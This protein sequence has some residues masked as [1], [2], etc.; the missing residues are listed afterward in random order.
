MHHRVVNNVDEEEFK[1]HTST[2]NINIDND[3]ETYSNVLNSLIKNNNSINR[4]S[5]HINLNEATIEV[6]SKPL[7]PPSKTIPL[8]NFDPKLKIFATSKPA[9]DFFNTLK[10]DTYV[11]SISGDAAIGKSTFL[12]CFIS[13]AEYFGKFDTTPNEILSDVPYKPIFKIGE[14]TESTTQGIDLYHIVIEGN[15]NLLILD[16]EGDNDPNRQDF[17]NWFYVN[18]ITTAISVSHFHNYHFP[19]VPQNTFVKYIKSS[20]QLIQNSKSPLREKVQQPSFYFVKRDYNYKTENQKKIDEQKTME[21]IKNVL[22]DNILK[23]DG[24]FLLKMPTNHIL[25]VDQHESCI[26]NKEVI[27][28]DCQKDRY[29]KTLVNFFFSIKF[30]MDVLQG[31]QDGTQFLDELNSILIANAKYFPCTQDSGTIAKFRMLKLTNERDRILQVLNSVKS[32]IVKQNLASEV[33]QMIQDYP[34]LFPK[35]DNE[36]EMLFS[37]QNNLNNIILCVTRIDLILGEFKKYLKTE[38]MDKTYSIL[39]FEELSVITQTYTNPLRTNFAELKMNLQDYQKSVAIIFEKAEEVFAVIKDALKL[40]KE[41]KK[42]GK[43]T[44]LLAIPGAAASIVISVAARQAAVR[45][46]GGVVAVTSVIGIAAGIYSIYSAKKDVD[47]KMAQLKREQQK[48]ENTVNVENGD[49]SL[50]ANVD[51]LNDALTFFDDFGKNVEDK[52]SKVAAVSNNE[53]TLEDMVLTFETFL[54]KK[55][56]DNVQVSN[57]S[58]HISKISQLLQDSEQY[59]SRIREML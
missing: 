9:Q 45:V 10:G 32:A 2:T 56:E 53:N 46:L 58:E 41:S 43:A 36:R 15:K 50:S 12:N 22:G 48:V 24:L 40:F 34:D 55:L 26:T 23:E 25:G 35:G 20:S 52:K 1:T 39:S 33:Q 8:L 6:E 13:I 17:G 51:M 59:T 11:L 3:V 19:K 37:I 47:K 30:Q 28:T 16:I 14:G 44:S 18:L 38:V 4:F 31:Y 54:V 49:L 7:P 42:T 27:C 5:T 21:T 29:F 57:E